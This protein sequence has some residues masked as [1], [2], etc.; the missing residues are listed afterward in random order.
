MDGRYLQH[1]AVLT[2]HR[3]GTGEGRETL[4]KPLSDFGERISRVFGE[5]AVT[6][7]AADVSTMDELGVDMDGY[8]GAVEVFHFEHQMG[9]HS[10]FLQHPA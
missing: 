8:L 9:R 1:E 4:V 10:C 5:P 6:G 3:V 2:V 7:V